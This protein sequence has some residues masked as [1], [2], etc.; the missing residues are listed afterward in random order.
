MASRSTQRNRTSYVP[1]CLALLLLVSLRTYSARLLRPTGNSDGAIDVAKE[2][3]EAVVDKY[4]P[5]LL[6]MLPRAQVPPSGPSGGT[7]DAPRN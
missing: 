4:A 2:M 3:K 1:V 6:A 5:L 7:N